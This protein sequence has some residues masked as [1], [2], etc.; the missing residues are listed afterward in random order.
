MHNEI[1]LNISAK[2]ENVRKIIKE[3]ENLSDDYNKL[4]QVFDIVSNLR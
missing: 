3:I 4:Q 2:D 1:F